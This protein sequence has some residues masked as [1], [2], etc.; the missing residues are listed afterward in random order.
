MLA[1]CTE[2]SLPSVVCQRCQASQEGPSPAVSCQD[3]PESFPGQGHIGNLPAPRRVWLPY[4]TPRFS[5]SFQKIRLSLVSRLP[6]GKDWTD[7]PRLA[8]ETMCKLGIRHASPRTSGCQEHHRRITCDMRRWGRGTYVQVDSRT[9]HPWACWCKMSSNWKVGCGV[10]DWNPVPVVR[11][12]TD[13]WQWKAELVG[14]EGRFIVPHPIWSWVLRSEYEMPSWWHPSSSPRQDTWGFCGSSL[15]R[16]ACLATGPTHLGLFSHQGLLFH[17]KVFEAHMGIPF[18][19]SLCGLY[20][21]G[22]ELSPFWQN[23]LSLP[24]IASLNLPMIRFSKP[25]SF[26]V[27]LSL[28]PIYPAFP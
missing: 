28:F 16:Q 3:T 13:S 8:L 5:K 25:P 15:P 7:T 14:G 20:P 18:L 19:P 9:C 6:S 4:C 2:A 17:T 12:T 11:L 22:L 27:L 24:E 23:H 10:S 1:S 26:L 21:L